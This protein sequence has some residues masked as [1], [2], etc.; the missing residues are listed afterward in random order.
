MGVALKT[1]PKGASLGPGAFGGG[2]CGA[3]LALG[4]AWGRSCRAGFLILDNIYS[5]APEL[6][7][8]PLLF[9]PVFLTYTKRLYPVFLTIYISRIHM[10][11]ILITH[12]SI[13]L[14]LPIC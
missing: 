14:N 7:G 5:F 1:G 4:Q 11:L 12:D 2:R 8:F 3:S 9:Y 10:K 6:F 13:F